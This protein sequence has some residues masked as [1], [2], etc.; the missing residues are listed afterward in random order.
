MARAVGSPKRQFS[1]ALLGLRHCPGLAGREHMQGEGAQQPMWGF[2]RKGRGA[3]VGCRFVLL[4]CGKIPTGERHIR[5][6]Q[7][8]CHPGLQERSSFRLLP[9]SGSFR[10]KQVS[11]GTMV[12]FH[13]WA[14][15]G[16]RKGR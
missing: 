16:A 14:L 11:C 6:R 5:Q 1:R 12:E 10:E 4:Q 15:A 8:G 9:G 13:I 7:A 2:E 3:G